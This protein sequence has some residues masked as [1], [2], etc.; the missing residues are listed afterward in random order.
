M[1]QDLQAAIEALKRAREV[2]R[3][4]LRAIDQALEALGAT[5]ESGQD[6]QASRDFEDFGLTAAAKR[7]LRESGTPRTTREIADAL[8]ERGVKTRSKNYIATVYAT[9]NNSDFFKR[10]KDGTWELVEAAA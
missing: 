5:A 7:Y 9:L 4:E 2:K 10:T 1:Q 8:M 6:R 3:S